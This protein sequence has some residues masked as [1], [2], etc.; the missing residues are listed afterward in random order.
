M[1]RNQ[2]GHTTKHPYSSWVTFKTDKGARLK[3]QMLRHWIYTQNTIQ[4]INPDSVPFFLMYFLILLFC[5]DECIF[6]TF[7]GWR[8]VPLS[9]CYSSTGW[10]TGE[11]L[12]SASTPKMSPPNPPKGINTC[13]LKLNTWSGPR[14]VLEFPTIGH[15][16]FI[17][18]LF[19]HLEI[20]GTLHLTHSYAQWPD[21]T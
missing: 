17:F 4:R 21:C 12:P 3:L 1:E 8:L 7:H 10:Q 13:L 6:F 15:V 16:N 18:T 9:C 2:S 14:Y 11:K 20:S 5:T 19:I